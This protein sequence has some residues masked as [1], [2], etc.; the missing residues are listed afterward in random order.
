MRT[1]LFLTII[2]LTLCISCSETSSK[3]ADD[4]NPL[5]GSW[6]FV[7][8]Q[9]LDSNDAVIDRDTNVDGI[10]I[11]APDGKMNVQL[12]YAGKRQKIMNDTIMNNDGAS[13]HLGLGSN[14]WSIEETR[15]MI[16]TYDAYF[17]D[18]S[19]DWQNKIITH[20]MSGNL[21]P[22]KKGTVYKRRFQLDHDTLLL[23]DAKPG[24]Y[25]RVVWVR[26][27]S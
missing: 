26:N 23:R 4:T 3:T 9:E 15:T 11:Y 2:L 22:E 24:Q 19:I 18:Y 6:R 1:F 17:G 16:D 25:W 7:E 12:L 8:E 27:K 5:L 20:T 13:M 10:L 14:T 21:R